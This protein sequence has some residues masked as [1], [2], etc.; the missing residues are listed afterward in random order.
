MI[1]ESV[2]LEQARHRLEAARLLWEHDFYGESISRL[3]FAVLAAAH[4]LF[5]AYGHPA[6]TH[7]GAHFLL[8]AHFSERIDAVLYHRLWV[9]REAYDYELRRPGQEHV[10]RRL[11]EAKG[12]ID[13]VARLISNE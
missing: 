6:K 2:W 1:D 8:Y 3:Y 12:F 13:T 5:T 4:A 10:R 9:E 11:D 7:Q